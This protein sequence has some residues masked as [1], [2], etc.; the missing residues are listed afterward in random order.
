M[1]VLFAASVMTD[2]IIG[3]QLLMCWTGYLLLQVELLCAM[4]YTG[5]A[6]C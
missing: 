3:Y 6:T 4:Y 2:T 1:S 5:S